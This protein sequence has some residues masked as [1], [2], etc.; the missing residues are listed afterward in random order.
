[1]IHTI[2]SW[3]YCFRNFFHLIGSLAEQNYP[4]DKYELI[5]VEQ[6]DREASDA[7]NHNL[8]LRSLQDTVNA[9]R[10]RFNVRTVFLSRDY[11][12]PYHLGTCVPGAILTIWPLGYEV[13]I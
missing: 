8:G 5:F 13:R 10:N 4:K 7:Y 11:S 2:I 12:H 6:R 1:V 3:D 9:Y